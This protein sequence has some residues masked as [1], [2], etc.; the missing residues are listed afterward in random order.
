MKR[1]A[2]NISIKELVKLGKD[3]L[4]QE[5]ELEKRFGVKVNLNRRYL[6]GIINREPGCSDTWTLE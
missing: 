6:V 5:R 3:L 4:D 2:I 1:Q